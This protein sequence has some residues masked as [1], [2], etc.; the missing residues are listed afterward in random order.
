M[1]SA[2]STERRA[3]PGARAPL[4]L[5]GSFGEG[6]G[7]ILRTA[8]ALSLV[9]ATPFRLERIRLRRR[10]PGLQRQHLAAVRAAAEVGEAAVE[11]AE[12]GSPTLLFQPRSL[13]CG[14]FRFDIG[15]AGSATLVAQTVLPALLSAPGRSELTIDG[16][17]HN[18]LAPTFEFLSEA[19]LPLVARLGPELA[20]E[21]ERPGFFPAGGGRMRLT[22]EP[23]PL[24]PLRLEERGTLRSVTAEAQVAGLP[25]SIAERELAAA[26]AAL[27]RPLDAGEVRE[28]PASFGPGN[29]I[30]LRVDSAAVREL[31]TG[32][33]ERGVSAE[34]VGRRAGLEAKRY[35]ES[36][37]AIG[38]H[39]AD[40]LLLPVAL[41]GGGSFSTVRPSA[42]FS[43]NVWVIGQF[44]PIAIR[45]R[46]RA[47]DLFDV[48]I[49]ASAR[50]A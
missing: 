19:F 50:P 21:L 42:H 44:L 23:A 18:P 10:S 49:G 8:L 38:S 1:S 11:G 6:G 41:A 37:A 20:A 2:R 30:V 7:Q 17:T 29:V 15:S 4:A 35:L 47:A 25:R 12:L 3:S 13:R 33:G 34:R 24:A 26:A 27:G 43:T 16:G 28:W 48:E 14:S 22:I 9:T 40:Q 5:D 45:A 39:L 46:E 32:F 31:F 36:G